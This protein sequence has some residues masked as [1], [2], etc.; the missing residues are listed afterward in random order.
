LPALTRLLDST[1][2]IAL[3]QQEFLVR[4]ENISQSGCLVTTPRTLRVGSVGCLRVVLGR[5]E[6]VGHVRVVRCESVDGQSWSVGVEL[7]WIHA[8]EGVRDPVTAPDPV[9]S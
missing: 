5:F 7:L 1:D 9:E 3:L 2:V 6:Y 4:L 8:S